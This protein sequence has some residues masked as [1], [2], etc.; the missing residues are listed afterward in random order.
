M[1]KVKTV[2]LYTQQYILFDRVLL[3]RLCKLT[4]RDV[5]TGG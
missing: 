4:I 3:Q 2:D 5:M 1:L